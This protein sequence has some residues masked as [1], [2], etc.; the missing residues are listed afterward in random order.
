MAGPAEA[1]SH[2]PDW[3]QY[4]DNNVITHNGIEKGYLY[5]IIDEPVSV[6][7]DLA[8]HLR[9]AMDP[10]AEFVFSRSLQVKLICEL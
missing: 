5:I 6:G 7:A 8:P 2:Q 3:L 1:F 4:D 9:T 10:D